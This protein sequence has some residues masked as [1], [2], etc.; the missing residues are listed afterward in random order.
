MPLDTLKAKRRLVD[1]FGVEDQQA[2]GIVELIANAEERGVTKANLDAAEE[3]I[4]R[5]LTNR[6]YAAVAFVTAALTLVN[7]LIG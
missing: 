2:E 5:T 1:E 7:Y 6:I 3:R 4:K